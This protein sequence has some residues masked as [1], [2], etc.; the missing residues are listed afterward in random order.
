MLGL[1]GAGCAK[2]GRVDKVCRIP[3]FVVVLGVM[4]WP[5]D[6]GTTVT[7][8]VPGSMV[9]EAPAGALTKGV[10]LLGGPGP[11]CGFKC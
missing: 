1:V 6:A 5:I 4:I 2:I 9:M 3:G 7:F 10:A 11:S 8:P